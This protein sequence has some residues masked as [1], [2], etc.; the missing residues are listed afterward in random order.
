MTR[1]PLRKSLVLC[2]AVSAFLLP[3]VAAQAHHSFAMFDA[4]NKLTLSGTVKELQWVNPHV[5]LLVY[6]VPSTGEDPELWT[7]ELTSPG[8]LTRLGWTRHSLSPGDKVTVDIAPLRDGTHGGAFQK[9]TIVDTGKVLT[10]NFKDQE[11]PDL[12]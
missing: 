6:A 12:Q 1:S 10:S 11:H 5:T 7:V 3:R 4:S 9:L 2:L 8:N